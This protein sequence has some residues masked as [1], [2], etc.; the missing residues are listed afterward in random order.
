[1]KYTGAKIILEC[2]NKMGVDC[3]FGYPGGSILDIYEEIYKSKG[4]IKHYLM[5]S[6]QGATFAADGY[7]RASGKVGVVLATLFFQY[8]H[9]KFGLD[10]VNAY[11]QFSYGLVSDTLEV[12]AY[13]GAFHSASSYNW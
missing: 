2:L 1:M 10:N 11:Q 4:K 5:S 3:I 6:E 13:F 7:S 8:P 12:N 9:F